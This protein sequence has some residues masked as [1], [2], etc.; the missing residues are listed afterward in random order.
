MSAAIDMQHHWLPFTNN[1]LFGESPQIFARAEGVRYETPDGATIL[2][3][4]SGLFCTPAGHGR[5]EIADAVHR[6]LL[7]LDYTPHFQRAAPNS[8][9]LATRLAAILPAGL[10]R[11]F[12][13]SSGSE[14]VDSAMKICLTY[15]R[16]KGEGQRSRFV[17]RNWGYHGVNLGGTSL[18]GMVNNRRE[19]SGVTA[20]VVHMRQTW[21][22]DQRYSPGQPESGAEL[23]DDL[24]EICRTYGAETIAGVF[25]EP[26]AGSIGTVVPPKGYLERLRAICDR[27]GLL[28]VFDEVITGFGRT[29]AP[30]AAQAFDVTPDLMTM[31]KALTNGAIPMSAVAVRRE[32][33]DTIFAAAGAV[34][35]PELFHGYTYSAHPVACAAALATLDIYRDEALFERAAA[36]SPVFLDAIFGL[37]NLAQVTDLRGY[38]MMAGIQLKPGAAP[39]AKGSLVQRLLFDAG[40]HVKATGDALIVAP[41]FVASEDEIAQMVAVLQQVLGRSDLD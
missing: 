7:T 1:R 33:Q 14:A 22:E 8:F 29:G 38:G 24:E 21:R 16:A 6:Q 40:L 30:F 13:A 26:I 25:V 28:L 31:A 23:A 10:D 35:R 34:D 9:A 32:I 15:H 12:F 4:S 19:F 41:A 36:L 11:I 5:R 17:S 27:H 3:G 37:R 39:G 18:A 20:D 2:D